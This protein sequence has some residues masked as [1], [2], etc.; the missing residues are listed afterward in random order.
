[1]IVVTGA[2]G[3]VGKEVVNI[4]AKS[5]V[6]FVAMSRDVEAAKTN[7]S[8][9]VKWVSGDFDDAESIECALDGASQ[10]ILISPAGEQM[11][12]QQIALV[13]AAKKSGVT[14]I[15][16]L[17]GLGAGPEAPI[18]LPKAHYAIEQEIINLGITY[19]FVRPNLFMQVLNGAVQEDGK[20]YAPAG[21]AKIS[22]TDTRDIAE[23]MVKSVLSNMQNET[24]EVTGPEAVSYTDVAS[25]ITHKSGSSVEYVGVSPEDAK[26]S[27]L[28]M[29]MA[30]WL[31]DAFIELF[32]IYREGHG[33]AIL[34]EPIRSVLGREALN[35]KTFVEKQFH[36]VNEYTVS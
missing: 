22:F 8:P 12:N 33:E 31:V 13:R 1:M 23:L 35:I 3:N 9:S 26:N 29:G 24:I 4:L 5:N 27:M 15:V 2:T 20:I 34:D 7:F 36:I 16:K 10:L 32:E 30:N 25:M 11:E 17:S 18:R 28:G 21:D 6:D 19:V 14:K